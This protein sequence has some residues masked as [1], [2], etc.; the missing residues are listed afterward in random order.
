MAR[1]VYG[2]IITE[3]SFCCLCITRVSAAQVKLVTQGELQGDIL[4]IL[5]LVGLLL[6]DVCHTEVEA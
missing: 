1:F 2:Y 3:S 6:V 4:H 5:V